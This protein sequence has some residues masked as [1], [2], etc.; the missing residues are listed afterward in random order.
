MYGD[1]AFM[2]TGDAPIS[3]ENF[4]VEAYGSALKSDVLK[5]GHHG[6]KTS[7]SESFLNTVAPTY[8]VVSSGADNQYGHPHQEVMERVRARNLQ[9]F[10]TSTDGTIT[11]VSDGKVVRVE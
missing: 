11:F 6:S 5:L 9:I 3:I 1:T 8:A 10:Q 4:L 7:S 2:L